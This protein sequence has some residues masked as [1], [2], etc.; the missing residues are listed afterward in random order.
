MPNEAQKDFK[1]V[2]VKKPTAIIKKSGRITR[3]WVSKGFD[4]SD[5]RRNAPLKPPTKDPASTDE[6]AWA[7]YSA[8]L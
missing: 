5:S 6:K 7:S 4:P 3:D 2:A 1:D 8:Y